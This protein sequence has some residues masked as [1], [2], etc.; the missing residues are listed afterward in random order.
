MSTPL[1]E[2]QYERCSFALD[3]LECPRCAGRLEIIAFIAEGSVAK[4]ILDHLGLD[5]Q[6]PP[7]ARARSPDDPAG[8]G[9]G[10]PDYHAADPTYDE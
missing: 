6:G 7:L 4:R 9:D 5:A 1:R 3:V 10:G 2:V 8:A